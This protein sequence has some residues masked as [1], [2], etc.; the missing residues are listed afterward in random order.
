LVATQWFSLL[1][2]VPVLAIHKRN[3]FENENGLFIISNYNNTPKLQPQVINLTL[4]TNNQT[5]MVSTNNKQ[6]CGKTTTTRPQ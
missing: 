6:V 2:L 1:V 5:T 3:S 4:P